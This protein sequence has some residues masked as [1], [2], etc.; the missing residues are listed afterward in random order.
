VDTTG[1][2]PNVFYELGFAHTL[3][4]TK[5]IIITQNIEVAPFDIA[6]INHIYYWMIPEGVRKRKNGLTAH[7]MKVKREIEKTR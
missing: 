5:A 4:N 2:N 6:E 1:R 7:M 3:S